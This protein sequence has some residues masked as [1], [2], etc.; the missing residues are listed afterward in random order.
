[1]K[2]KRWRVLLERA[3]ELAPEEELVQALCEQVPGAVSVEKLRA[4][5]L[6]LD[7]WQTGTM[8]EGDFI[9]KN[10]EVVQDPYLRAERAQQAWIDLQRRIESDE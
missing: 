1:M 8:V 9:R 6:K 7:R 10:G 3:I 5:E 2:D 4:V